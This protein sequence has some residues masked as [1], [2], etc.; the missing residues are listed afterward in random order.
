MPSKPL[1]WAGLKPTQAQARR[2]G[3]WGRLGRAR[4]KTPPSRRFSP[5]LSRGCAD[6]LQMLW[7]VTDY[8]VDTVAPQSPSR[9]GRFDSPPAWTS[10]PRDVFRMAL[11]EVVAGECRRQ[12]W[13]AGR[14]VVDSPR[15]DG[16]GRNFETE[17]PSLPSTEQVRLVWS[18]GLESWVENSSRPD[19]FRL[20]IAGEV[21]PRG[22]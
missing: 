14:R 11:A 9:H 5:N 3:D 18:V 15:E 17:L 13:L 1:F 8:T 12:S 19:G 6:A 21:T 7:C 10:L 22:V 16:T 20:K 4:Q 2:R